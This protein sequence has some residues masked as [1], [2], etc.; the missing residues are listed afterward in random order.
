VSIGTDRR[1]GALRRRRPRLLEVFFER[2]VPAR[3]EALL[4]FVDGELYLRSR[5]EL[6]YA[7][8]QDQAL[9]D[10]WSSVTETDAG[11]IETPAGTVRYLAVPIQTDGDT[12][13]V[14]VAAGFRDV[15]ATVSIDPAV[16]GGALVGVAAV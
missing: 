14:F 2:N 10:R 4:T 7:L 13:A 9:V 8:D 15:E 6:P 5:N 3:N 12:R 11:S 16:R 1:P